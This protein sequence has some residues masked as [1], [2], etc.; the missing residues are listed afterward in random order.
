MKSRRSST[1]K[2]SRATPWISSRRT[3]TRKA[4]SWGLAT[5]APRRS[6]ITEPLPPP[7]PRRSQHPS[8]NPFR[9][10]AAPL[11]TRLK[12]KFAALIRILAN[13]PHQ[14]HLPAFERGRT[15]EGQHNSKCDVKVH[16]KVNFPST[17]R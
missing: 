13:L 3:R 6:S 15:L 5:A 10:F 9:P 16:L 14:A 7:K 11:A 1:Q 8:P 17:F 12:A 2:A 4:K